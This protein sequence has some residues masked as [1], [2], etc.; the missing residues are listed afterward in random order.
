MRKK[1][2][3]IA[4]YLL[5]TL[6]WLGIWQFAAMRVGKELLFP[7]PLSVARRIVE[8]LGGVTL[9][10]TVALSLLRILIGMLI[11]TL[12]GA[13]GG[14]LTALIKAQPSVGKADLFNAF[15]LHSFYKD[16]IVFHTCIPLCFFLF[17]LVNK[18]ALILLGSHTRSCL[19]HL[20][21]ICFI[22]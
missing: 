20:A 11:G 18:S 14:L 16:L 10:K 13:I 15:L 6:I 7:T 5:I 1:I 4:K 9:Y 8:L 21:K 22:Q 2:L 19:E 12:I 17:R 3:K